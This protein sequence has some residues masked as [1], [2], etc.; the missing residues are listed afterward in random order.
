[1][2]PIIDLHCDLLY[3]LA[4][5]PRRSP[6]DLPPRCSYPQLKAGNVKL[7]VLA[8]YTETFPGSQHQGWKQVERFDQLLTQYADQFSYFEGGFSEQVQILPAIENGSCFCGEEESLN[9]GLRR[10]EQLIQKI[11]KP[12]YIGLTWNGENRFGGGFGS[13]AGLKSDGLELLKWLDQKQIAI[14]F[15]H[16]SDR[17]CDELFNAIDKY[18]LKLPVLASHCNFRTIM[19]HGRNLTDPIAKE[20]FK[21]KGVAGIVFY[22]KFIHPTDYKVV[23][24]HIEHGLK[25]GGAE[26]LCFGADFFCVDDPFYAPINIAGFFDELSDSSK[27]PHLIE[28]MQKQFSEEQIK[29]IAS[30]NY[31][32]F[33]ESAIVSRSSK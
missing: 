29:K 28:L 21:R 12:L 33:H 5:D 15:S 18:S 7:Q 20:I 22:K 23:L 11:G 31:M 17:L 30:E 25:L 16:A 4:Q 14:D 3:Y 27:Y 13:K 24:K 26:A 2:L 1:M 32:A 19:D 9:A 6:F 8:I 10:L